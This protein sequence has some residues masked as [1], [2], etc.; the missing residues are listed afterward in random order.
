MVKLLLMISLTVDMPTTWSIYRVRTG[1]AAAL[2]CC[3]D[4]R[5]SSCRTNL[6]QLE[7]LSVSTSHCA[8]N[9]RK[10]T[11]NYLSYTAR[12]LRH[13]PVRSWTILLNY[14][15]TLP[16]LWTKLSYV[17]ILTSSTTI[18]SPRMSLTLL[19]YLIAQGLFSPWRVQHNTWHVSGNVLDLVIT[20]RCSNMITSP[21]IPTTLLTDHHA[22]ECELRYGKPSRQTSAIS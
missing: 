6:W 5:F 18:P 8:A 16:T 17:A 13:C 1:V 9:E 19:I 4:Q 3:S 15:T 12:L 2:V 20:H 7:R 21:V 10:S 22:V 11:F 14:W